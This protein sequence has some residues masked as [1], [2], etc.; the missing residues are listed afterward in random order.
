MPGDVIVLSMTGAASAIPADARVLEAVD[1]QT[2]ETALT[3]ES[4]P[5]RKT[6]DAVE[7]DEGERFYRN[8]VFAGTAVSAGRGL[9]LVLRTGMRTELG[10][11]AKQVSG[12]RA[13]KT[14]LQRELAWVSFV[15]FCVG[16]IFALIVFASN[17]F[18][19]GSESA[20]RYTAVYA[21]AVVVA[22]IPEELPLVLTLTCAGRAA[23]DGS[24]RHCAPHVRLGGAGPC[25]G[26]LLGQDRHHHT[27]RH[28]CDTRMGG[29]SGV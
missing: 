13:Q 21:V 11:I 23:H 25:D 3:G 16:L 27:S 7:D 15:L 28:E 20:I 26:H 2:I 12:R 24:A 14:D 4:K 19:I 1:L 6:S 29:G 8:H 5:V 10:K 22:L 17:G 18:H 9:A